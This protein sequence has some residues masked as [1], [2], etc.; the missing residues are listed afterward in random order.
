MG[1]D[2]EELEAK[3]HEPFDPSVAFAHLL[4]SVRD[5][6]VIDACFPTPVDE[7]GINSARVRKEVVDRLPS[8]ERAIDIIGIFATLPVPV[9]KRFNILV[10]LRQ[11]DWHRGV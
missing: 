11:L 7:D 9:F 10:Y 5:M 4:N 1:L 2:D 3:T 6:E 8:R